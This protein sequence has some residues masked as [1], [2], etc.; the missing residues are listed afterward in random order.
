MDS[1]FKDINDNYFVDNKKSS[2]EGVY[3]IVI[4]GYTNSTYTLTVSQ[5]Q[6]KII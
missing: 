1:I 6:F 5:G 3:T 4:Y 2:L